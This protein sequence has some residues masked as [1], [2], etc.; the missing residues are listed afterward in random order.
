M[1]QTKLT[2]CEKLTTFKNRGSTNIYQLSI[3][4]QPLVTITT[5]LMLDL[6]NMILR[7]LYIDLQIGLK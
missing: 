3:M 6:Y 1:E 7:I 2:K 4:L 5:L